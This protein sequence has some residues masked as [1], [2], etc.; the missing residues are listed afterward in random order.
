MRH[1]E[2]AEAAL[3]VS[4]MRPEQAAIAGDVSQQRHRGMALVERQ[5]LTFKI[6]LRDNSA[7]QEL[8]REHAADFTRQARADN[9]LNGTQQ[10]AARAHLSDP[11]PVSGTSPP[12]RP[13]PRT[14][15]GKR[16][17]PAPIAYP[18]P[19]LFASV[20]DFYA[21]SIRAGVERLTDAANTHNH[22]V[23]DVNAKHPEGGSGCLATQS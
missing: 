7:K 19:A 2:R 21:A 5:T 4:P 22:A 9:F 17:P 20:D 14:R 3:S 18:N 6:R 23:G 15:V 10:K 12:P 16:P 13:R 11:G 8:C 1:I